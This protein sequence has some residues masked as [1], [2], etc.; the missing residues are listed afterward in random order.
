MSSIATVISELNSLNTEL[1]RLRIQTRTL[2]NRKKELEKQI[3][4][5]MEI[6]EQPGIKYQ[7]M[8]IIPEEKE[9]FR[10]KGKKQ[11]EVDIKNLLEDFGIENV[12]QAYKE[13]VEKMRGS[14]K[15]NVKLKIKKL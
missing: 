14:P 4:E 10:T 11:K 3:I 7:G 8:A 15:H 6:K 12:G 13:L 9:S 2:N 5:F 1:K